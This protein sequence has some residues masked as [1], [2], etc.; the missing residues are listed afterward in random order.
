MAPWQVIQDRTVVSLQPNLGSDNPPFVPFS[1]HLKQVTKYSPHSREGGSSFH[2]LHGG[3]L[4]NLWTYVKTTKAVSKYLGGD[5]LRLCN[6]AVS[7]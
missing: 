7:P 4:K 5:T 2:L 6:S 3:V 1:V